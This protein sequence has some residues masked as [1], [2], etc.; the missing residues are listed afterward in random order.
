MHQI[1]RQCSCLWRSYKITLPSSLYCMSD[2]AP[3]K[4]LCERQTCVVCLKKLFG[5]CPWLPW[6]IWRVPI[7]NH[8]F[9]V[10]MHQRIYDTQCWCIF[11]STITIVLVGAT[12]WVCLLRLPPQYEQCRRAQW[13][14]WPPFPLGTLHQNVNMFYQTPPR[15]RTSM[16]TWLCF[17][18]WTCMFWAA[19]HFI[20]SI[21]RVN[22]QTHWRP[23]K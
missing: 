20:R 17:Q 7:I 3:G 18:M 10:L 8:L 22:C 15:T 19:S 2:P 14:T 16:P 9:G 21:A 4:S 12:F 6:R 11:L 5:G 1:S 13:L 23:T